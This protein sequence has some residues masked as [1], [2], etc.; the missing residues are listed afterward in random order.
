MS[1][2]RRYA[3]YAAAGV[4]LGVGALLAALYS[5][6]FAGWLIPRVLPATLQVGAI[7]GSLA[8]GLQL[9]ALRAPG[10]AIERLAVAPAW[11]P[12][13]LGTPTLASVEASGIRID[14][15]GFPARESATPGEPWVWPSRT[16]RFAVAV[17]TLQDLEVA[18]APPAELLRIERAGWRGLRS[19]GDALE[20]EALEVEGP[21]LSAQLAGRLGWSG[22]SE[23]RAELRHAGVDARLTLAGSPAAGIELDLQ[24]LTPVAGRLRGR[25]LGLP[26]APTV[27]LGLTVPTVDATAL[28]VEA[29]HALAP[30]GADLQLQ[31]DLTALRIDGTLTVQDQTL[32]LAGS[33]IG[34][35]EGRLRLSPLQLALGE[36]QLTVE[37]EWPLAAEAAVGQLRLRGERLTWRELPLTLE[38]FAAELGGT[39][40]ALIFKLDAGVRHADGLLP[41]LVAGNFAE[42]VLLL[43]QLSLAT[44]A[45][46]LSGRLRYAPADTALDAELALRAVD[47]A[48]LLPEHPTRLDGALRIR[49]GSTGWRVEVDALRGAWRE[50]PLMLDGEV[51]WAGTGLPVG[52]LEAQVDGNRLSLQP[53][54]DGHEASLRLGRLAGILPGVDATG[55]IA[56]RQAGAALS[57]TVD[58]QQLRW[59]RDTRRLDL[60]SLQSEGRHDG[61]ASP[62]LEA[63]L[64]LQEL[65]EGETRYG[66]LTL[67]VTGREAAHRIVLDARTPWLDLALD[68]QGA[69]QRPASGPSWTGELAGLRLEPA[70]LAAPGFV[71]DGAQRLAWGGDRLQL[72]RGCLRREQAEVCV[73]AELSLAG[74]PGR[75]ELDLQGL[76]LSILPRPADAAWSLAGALA[77]RFALALTGSTPESLEASLAS[78]ALALTISDEE[79]S[80]TLTLDELRMTASGPLA[81]LGV[82]LDAVL[83][84]AGP[85]QLAAR[86]IG[87]ASLEAALDVDFASLA[88]LDGWSPELVAADGKLAG[89]LS[90]AGAPEQLQ[91]GGAL[92]LRDF[93]AEVPAAGLK[94]RE[95]ELSLSL[96]EPGKL[97]VSGRIGS[98]Q[99]PLAIEATAHLDEAGQP[100]LE[101][102][103]RGAQVLV[104]DLPNLR[105]LASPDLRL[106]TRDGVLRVTGTLGLPEGRIDLERFEPA[107]SAS[108]DVVVLDRPV[109]APAPVQT[110]VRY[111]LGPALKLKGFGLDAGLQGGVRVRSRP[112]RPIT[113]TGTVDLSG[114]YRAYGQNLTIDRGRLLWTNAPIGNPGFDF[115][116]YRTIEQ[117]KAGVRVRGS[118]TA[119][120]LTVYTEPPREASD[121]LSWLVLG[122]PLS[123]ASGDDGQQLSAAAGALGSVG[124]AL[125]GATIGQRLGV[126]INVESSA[127]LGGSPAF[128]VGKMLSPKLFVGFG[129]SLFDSAQLVIVRYRL[130]EHYELEALSGRETKVGANYRIER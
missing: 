75:V 129:R 51:D 88:L 126:E 43:E 111:T 104:A 55:R 36:G 11:W 22:G 59:E 54:A 12:S 13:L 20:I 91:F 17:L 125:I 70:G 31:G 25:V 9:D 100:Q 15:S 65:R 7:R 124:G 10:V 98:G 38:Q 47:L 30:L 44:G 84:D 93:A 8:S 120:E 95:G 32:Q 106:A 39:S 50:L 130:T 103:L 6:S 76:D 19:L 49:Q 94:L 112:G 128:T 97:A 127:E 48:V 87:S 60:R 80:K 81:D 58:L 118:A 62:L 37:G 109:A 64:A 99:G 110:D 105:L 74:A 52:R 56:L 90:V 72:E 2:V 29:L 67:S 16:P 122:R 61:G 108:P 117:L 1:R 114:G 119:P 46:E 23:L 102:T 121:A 57:W 24:T 86:G 115:S 41:V 71:L 68:A 4:L 42:G 89:R 92:Q 85:L 69:L 34:A 28:G 40:Q 123:S 18:A 35:D 66:P 63:R 33:R 53:T 96:P 73:G 79:R 78:T 83:R 27:E 107:V 14:P 21:G 45:G 116:A 5:T 113:A 101:A 82:N 77:G 26:A 3:L